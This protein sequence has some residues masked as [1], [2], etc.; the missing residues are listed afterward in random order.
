MDGDI[1]LCCD[2]LLLLY[3]ADVDVLEEGH[4]FVVRLDLSALLQE[5]AH[6]VALGLVAPGHGEC[7]QE[8]E[9]GDE[10]GHHRPVASLHGLGQLER[11]HEAGAQEEGVDAG[12]VDQRAGQAAPEVAHEPDGPD[13]PMAKTRCMGLSG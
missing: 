5:L 12:D 2:I 3:F 6:E 1:L 11:Q 7:E 13:D 4:V 9:Q 8:A 10:Y